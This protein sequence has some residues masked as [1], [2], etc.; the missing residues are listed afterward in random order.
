MLTNEPSLM[1]RRS[2]LTL[3]YYFKIKC[4]LLNPAYECVLYDTL[5][6][7]LGVGGTVASAFIVRVGEDPSIQSS[8]TTCIAFQDDAKAHMG[9]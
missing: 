7:Q 8:N 2:E 9:T 6:R 3:K 1:L 5:Q 4:C